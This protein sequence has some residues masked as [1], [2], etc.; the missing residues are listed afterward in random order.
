M[1]RAAVGQPRHLDGVCES[2]QAAGTTA[3]QGWLDEETPLCAH[4]TDRRQHLCTANGCGRVCTN[5]CGARSCSGGGGDESK[6]KRG[7]GNARG[8]SWARSTATWHVTGS[9]TILGGGFAA[10]RRAR[11]GTT[12]VG[13]GLCPDGCGWPCP[14]PGLRGTAWRPRSSTNSTTCTTPGPC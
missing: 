9:T 10:P 14:H 7:Q 11:D 4:A 1:A 12:A 13:R 2:G 8:C 3:W 5:A 6:G